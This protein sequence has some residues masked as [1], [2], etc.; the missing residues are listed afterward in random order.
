MPW[1]SRL[2]GARIWMELEA[3][4]QAAGHHVEHFSLTDAF[5]Q[6]G[7]SRAGFALRQA[8]F[9][10]RAANYVRKNSAAFDVI[11]ALIGSL[12]ASKAQLKF[13]GL[14]VA[15]SI[16]LNQLYETFEQSVRAK[17]SSERG[18]LPGRVLYSLL[19]RRGLQASDQ[20]LANADL[21][22]VPNATEAQYL[23]DELHITK[24]VIVQPYGLTEEQRQA[25]V[26]AA[27]PTAERLVNKT[28]SFVGMWSARKGAH[29]WPHIIER[30]R[31]QVPNARFRFL[32]TMVEDHIIA[33]DLTRLDPAAY[34]NNPTY[35]PADLPQLLSDCALGAFPSYVEGFGLAVL[36]QLAAGIPTVA[37]DVAGPRDMLH[38]VPELLVPP[39]DHS[40]FAD[41]IATLLRDEHRRY[42][43]LAQECV[44]AAANFDWRA[45]SADTLRDYQVG[46]KRLETDLLLIQPF[47]LASAG[48]GARILRALVQEA[49]ASWLSVCCAP[50]SPPRFE[51]EVHLPTRPG[52]GKFEH[53]R[54]AM[55]PQLTTRL[56]QRRF[57][58]R[59][60]S[61]C[62]DRRVRAI[63]AVAHSC[64]DFATASSVAR[65]LRLP[66]LLSV[67][68]DV[69]Y[70]AQH[71]PSASREAA[72]RSAWNDAAA[73]F[74][75]SE[76]LG[77]EYA[78]RYGERDYIVVTDG[79]T[80][81]AGQPASPSPEKL[82]VYFMGMFHMAYEENLRAL[83]QG[84]GHFARSSGKVVTMTCRC[85]HIRSQLLNGSTAVTVLPFA[86]E[87]QVQHD[88]QKAD[89]LYLP[90]PFGEEH[91]SFARYSLSTKM[92]TYLG[93]G[94][95]ILYH[96]P[97]E[98]AAYELLTKY[99]AAVVA[100]S[101][102]PHVTAEVLSTI[103]A[104]RAVNVARN[105]LELAR[106]QF[107]LAEQRRKFW[108][109][110]SEFIG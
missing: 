18:T 82:R 29:D 104:E 90:I 66:F 34:E 8:R 67:H 96:G 60:L 1:D 25:F 14:L 76:G 33:K 65:E 27:L 79:V 56:F 63:H 13:S 62:K 69:A 89:L 99:N 72:M 43:T 26:E 7:T 16:G 87:Q 45:I 2:G 11:D 55:F 110:I 105:A 86:D 21:I 81:V 107:T 47:S 94:V 5:P 17:H 10:Q 106:A 49:P 109:A 59:L 83:L 58:R 42:S 20:S 92:V 31:N 64:L 102:D 85:E 71:L 32:G 93:S 88:I 28:V 9:A 6:A 51:G 23:R 70:T 22:N 38:S 15:R 12:P 77:R 101:L 19:R 57:Q 84:L 30:V 3:Q 97:A 73:C 37:Y 68:D 46:L 108:G 100:T 91:S 75:I 44:A 54:L 78:R 4:W 61:L 36:E 74:V 48:G 39:G 50:Q 95:P 35:D 40:R 80:D 98:S 41:A 52:W 53:S 103:T 24:P